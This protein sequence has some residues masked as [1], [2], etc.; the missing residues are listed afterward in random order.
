VTR[1]LCAIVLFGI[2][3]T[4]C[5]RAKPIHYY[6]LNTPISVAD[7]TA[8]YRV[9]LAVGDIDS[10]ALM[11]DGRILYQVGDHELGAYDYHRWVETPDRMVQNALA[12]MLRASGKY[13]A[14]EIQ[15]SGIRPDYLLTGRI[16]EFSEVDAAEIQTRVSMEIEL[17]DVKAGR[18]VWSRMY[19]HV[20]PVQ[21]REVPDV[22]ASLDRNLRRGLTE[23]MFGLQQYFAGLAPTP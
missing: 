22:V 5:V 13:A 16:F 21:G 4:A 9:T 12:R 15:S 14:V 1:Q 17:R 19:L 7:D 23:T 6:R 10:P 3:A 2:L 11:R 20:E 8:P 18:T